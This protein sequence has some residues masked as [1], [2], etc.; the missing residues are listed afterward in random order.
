MINKVYELFRTLNSIPRASHHEEKVADFLCQYAEDLGL[1]Y[2]R[3]EENCVVIR[4]PATPGHEDAEPVVLLNHM[5]MVAVGDP[6]LREPQGT[7]LAPEHLL[8]RKKLSSGQTRPFD[9]LRDGIEA[10]V[11]DGWMKAR[12]TSLGADNGI[13]LSMALAVLADPNVVHGP[14][15]VLTTTNEEDGMTGAAAMRTDFIKG[16]KVINLDSEDYDTIT[17]GAAGAYLQ[18]AKLPIAKSDVPDVDRFYKIQILGGL[19]GHS[20]VDINKGRINANQEMCHTLRAML[21]T[22]CPMLYLADIDGGAANASI[23]GSCTAI[24]GVPEA[25]EEALMKIAELRTRLLKKMYPEEPNLTMTIEKV[26]HKGGVIASTAEILRLIDHLP[27]GVIAL[28]DSLPD[29]PMTSNNIGRVF[30]EDGYLYVSCHTR[31]FD[32][33]EMVE[34]AKICTRDFEGVGADVEVV[35]NTPGWQENQQ[36]EYLQM[37]DETFRD[38]LGFSP[39]KVAMHFVLEAGYYVQKFPGIEIACIGPRIVEPHSTK[40]R[41]E[42]STVENICRVLVEL[43]KR[44]A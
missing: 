30:I 44:L 37:V 8:E 36:S 13:G 3:D 5:D 2:D 12:G 22:S 31:S 41:V 16:R 10:Y 18:V 9:P 6:S 4:K 34:W 29:T 40:E 33:D 19:G 17:V 7:P 15:E 20:G 42:L 23:P 43:L 24:V 25:E 27:C 39:R 28:H 14:L 11:E 32:D 26:E 35:M 1:E 38:V 21:E